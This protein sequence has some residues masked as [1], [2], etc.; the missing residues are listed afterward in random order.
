MVTSEFMWKDLNVWSN[1]NLFIQFGITCSSVRLFLIALFTWSWFELLF[2]CPKKP[3]K[4]CLYKI[5][6]WQMLQYENGLLL[7]WR[8]V[9]VRSKSLLQSWRRQHSDPQSQIV[10]Q[11]HFHELHLCKKSKP[12]LIPPPFRGFIFKM[13]SNSFFPFSFSVSMQK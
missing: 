2:G 10:S 8:G 13:L 4:L 5:T 1:A 11:L 7:V 3:E 6:N 9:F 12:S